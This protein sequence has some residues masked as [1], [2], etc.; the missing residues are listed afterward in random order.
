MI[1][2]IV[3]V[4]LGPVGATAAALLGSNGLHVAV[5][6]QATAVYDK[7]RAITLDHEIARVF[8]N[9]GIGTELQDFTAPHPGTHFLGVNGE[10]IKVSDPLPAPYPLGWPPTGTFLQPALEKALRERLN[11]LARVQIFDAHQAVAL[12][13]NSEHVELTARDS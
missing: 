1:Y 6:E 4:G 12:K 11:S 8:Q 9:C 3:I 2:D 10:V 13:Q 5:V 7:P